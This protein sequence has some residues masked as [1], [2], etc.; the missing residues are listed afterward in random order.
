MIKSSY[1]DAW[2]AVLD[3]RLN[4]AFSATFDGEGAGLMRRDSSLMCPAVPQAQTMSVD[5]AST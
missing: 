5:D 2:T 4:K 3:L 1:Q